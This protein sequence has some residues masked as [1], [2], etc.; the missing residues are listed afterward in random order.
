VVLIETKGSRCRR[1][2]PDAKGGWAWNLKGV[3]RMLYHLPQVRQA[4]VDGQPV[5]VVESEKSAD[6]LADLGLAATTHVGG[7]G[8][9]SRDY[10]ESLRGAH[11]VLLPD[12]HEPGR[13][14]AQ[15]VARSLRRKATSVRIITLPD[16]PPQGDVSGWVAAG[17]T[18]EQLEQLVAAAPEPQAGGA[19]GDDEEKGDEEQK[20]QAQ[21]L[22]RYAEEAV[23]F[24]D[25]DR[26]GYATVPVAAHHETLL[27]RSKDF[28]RWLVHSF[29]REHKKPPPDQAL[30]DVLKILE[31]KAIFDGPELP[32]HVRVAEL[33]G[34]IY[35]DLCSLQREV[36]EVT[37]EGWRILLSGQSPAKFRRARGMQ[38]L[39]QPVPGGRL[40]DLRGFLGLRDE[41]Q[42]RL[43]VGW[44]VM[45]LRPRGPY[46]VLG[47]H[48]EQ[49]SGKSTAARII[50]SVI[51]PHTVPLRSEPKE[52]SDLMI[53]AK[54]S[55]CLALDNL[56][57]LPVWLSDALCRLATGGGFG[58]RQLYTDDEEQ[59]FDSMRP[60]ILT[61][62]EAVARRPDLLD[63]SLLLELPTI[64][65][66]ERK[67]EEDLYAALKPLRP[68]ILGALLDAVAC[69]L[70]NLATV[71]L[72]FMPRLA[73]FAKWV[74]AAEPALGWE[75]GT[76]LATYHASQDEANDVALDAYSI[77]EPLRRLMGSLG[78]WEG[79]ASELLARLAERAGEKAVKARDWPKQPS[80]LSGQLKRLA[81]NLRKIGLDV[82]FGSVGGG[83]DKRR[84][85]TIEVV[86]VGD[87]S[88]PPSRSS[89]AL[90]KQGSWDDP[91]LD[92]DD[93]WDDLSPD[94]KAGKMGSGDGG[95]DGDD[96]FPPSSASP[97]DREEFE[98]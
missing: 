20:S 62:I 55:W 49:G 10:C 92:G 83:D 66:A 59:L 81:P 26:N 94:R 84:C 63:R 14:H 98:L 13:V 52:A 90:E 33:D 68:G 41:R 61:G 30:D 16:L 22:L 72:P 65:K 44:L 58:T 45:A 29:Y 97:P 9:W 56:S 71:Q 69:A 36:V 76:F 67:T 43:L 64:P 34:K 91:P 5:F 15:Q 53:A 96:R 95:D 4:I 6:A 74:T 24:H 12:N 86:G 50:R 75:P 7:A 19:A 60:V 38:A 47:V 32:V 78:R 31:A 18:R 80:V 85:I 25:A 82:T 79:T 93:P 40:D 51:D 54:N 21:A 37:P 42:W 11:V 89:L 35:L 27:L 28:G 1:P 2:D 77:V 39:P 3:Q 23:L 87:S 46:P 57:H 70:K 48:G 17:G 88:S 8:K 73:D